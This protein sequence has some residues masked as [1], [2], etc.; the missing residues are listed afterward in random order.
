[1]KIEDE[2]KELREEDELDVRRGLKGE[3]RCDFGRE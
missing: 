1:V 2:K 3:L